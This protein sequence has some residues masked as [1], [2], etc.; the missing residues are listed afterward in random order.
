MCWIIPSTTSLT[1]RDLKFLEK[2]KD[3]AINKSI[4]IVD[5]TDAKYFPYIE[6]SLPL[7]KIIENKNKK[8]ANKNQY[9]KKSISVVEYISA[10]SKEH[11]QISSKPRKQ[12][13][14]TQQRKKRK[15]F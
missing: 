7:P 9:E 10:M 14:V 13:L 4:P 3:D 15:K 11:E 5:E 2:C 1:R 12:I 6:N 8:K